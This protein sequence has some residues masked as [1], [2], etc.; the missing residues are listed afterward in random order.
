M[1]PP[2]EEEEAEAEETSLPLDL[3]DAAKTLKDRINATSCLVLY[4]GNEFIISAI[5]AMYIELDKS[6]CEFNNDVFN[7]D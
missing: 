6:I 2:R 4:T 1:P 3:I 7:P 5:T